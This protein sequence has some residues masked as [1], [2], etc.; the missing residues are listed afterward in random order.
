METVM[1][2]NVKITL[3]GI[4]TVIITLTLRMEVMGTTTET[5]LEVGALRNLAF[6]AVSLLGFCSY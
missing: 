2:R 3:T 5:V 4:S 6:D 1:E